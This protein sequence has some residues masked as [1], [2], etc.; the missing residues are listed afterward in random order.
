MVETYKFLGDMS[1]QVPELQRAAHKAHTKA[2]RDTIK[3]D[4]E[5]LDQ[6][7]MKTQSA[8]LERIKVDLLSMAQER[9]VIEVLT[10]DIVQAAQYS[11]RVLQ[12]NTATNRLSAPARAVVTPSG[13]NYQVVQTSTVAPVYDS[14]SLAQR[15]HVPE[16]VPSSSAASKTNTSPARRGSVPSKYARAVGSG[17]VVPNLQHTSALPSELRD[18]RVPTSNIL[19]MNPHK[20]KRRYVDWFFLSDLSDNNLATRRKSNDQFGP[21]AKT[22]VNRFGQTEQEVELMREQLIEATKK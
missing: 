4:S 7:N 2:L 9:V 18:I 13:K 12:G 6:E 16:F 10:R 19:A 15:I 1:S 20:P 3:F 8:E 21:F 11:R 5:V 17:Q 22:I 14:T